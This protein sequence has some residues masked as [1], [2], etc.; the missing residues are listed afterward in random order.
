MNKA[1]IFTSNVKDKYRENGV[2]YKDYHLLNVFLLCI[3]VSRQDID[4]LTAIFS[5]DKLAN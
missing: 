4:F 3:T 2:S 5:L 1:N